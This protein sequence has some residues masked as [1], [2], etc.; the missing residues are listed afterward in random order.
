MSKTVKC[1]DCKG[2]TRTRSSREV[3]IL[4]RQ[5]IIACANPECGGTFGAELSLTH[6]ISPSA[7]PDPSI[8]LR[9][10]PPRTRRLPTPA[11]DDPARGP[12]VPL[13][14]AANDDDGV[15]EAIATGH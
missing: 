7:I 2:P 15:H 11:N 14:L 13:P 10:A 8:D 12:E 3:T 1:P 6:R 5:L 9:M 4:Y